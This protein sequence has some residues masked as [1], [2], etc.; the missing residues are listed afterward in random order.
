MDA[1]AAQDQDLLLH[2]PAAM[3]ATVS[4]EVFARPALMAATPHTVRFV[5]VEH[6][7]SATMAMEL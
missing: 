7:C 5:A 1:R 3:Q 4:L 6:A 2:A